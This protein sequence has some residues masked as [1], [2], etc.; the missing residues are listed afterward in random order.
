[1][2]IRVSARP[3]GPSSTAATSSAV[4]SPTSRGHDSEIRKRLCRKTGSC[5][6]E[7]RVRAVGYV[8]DVYPRHGR[9]ASRPSSSM[10]TRPSGVPNAVALLTAKP[11]MSRSGWADQHEALDRKCRCT[12]M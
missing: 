1:M 2:T 11:A 9:A 4:A 5:T 10:G 6:S 12:P 7:G 8:V 3:T